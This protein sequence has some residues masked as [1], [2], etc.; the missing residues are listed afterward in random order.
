VRWVYIVTYLC[1]FISSH[2]CY[3]CNRCSDNKAIEKVRWKKS[4][5]NH[6]IFITL[7]SNITEWYIINFLRIS[8]KREPLMNDTAY[9]TNS[10]QTCMSLNYKDRLYFVIRNDYDIWPKSR[11]VLT[12]KLHYSALG[13]NHLTGIHLKCDSYKHNI[14][15]KV[16]LHIN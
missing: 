16:R 3:K 2:A 5:S 11:N 4:K 15:Y 10:N 6:T 1:H 8:E 12:Y 7:Y 14:F 9:Y 13:Y